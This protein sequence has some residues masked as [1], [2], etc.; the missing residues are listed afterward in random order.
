MSVSVYL[1]EMKL[2]VGAE[3][4]EHCQIVHE[5]NKAGHRRHLQNPKFATNVTKDSAAL[6]HRYVGVDVVGEIRKRYML[7]CM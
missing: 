6:R 1:C 4:A 7:A 2:C 3:R 5:S